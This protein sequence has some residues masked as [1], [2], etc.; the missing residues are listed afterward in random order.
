MLRVLSDVI[1]Q[2]LTTANPGLPIFLS[3]AGLRQRAPLSSR[4][5]AIFPK[6]TSKLNY[7]NRLLFLTTLLTFVLFCLPLSSLIPGGP[8]LSP[9]LSQSAG[10]VGV[11][12]TAGLPITSKSPHFYLSV[13]NSPYAC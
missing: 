4:P 10:G 3:V 2:I 11:G 8:I 13:A 9:T 6:R 5:Q 7:V 1:K 12:M